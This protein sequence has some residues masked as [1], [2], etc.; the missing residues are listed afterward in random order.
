MDACS[1]QL[2]AAVALLE[3]GQQRGVGG[4]VPELLWLARSLA[5]I[6]HSGSSSSVRAHVAVTGD[7]VSEPIWQCGLLEFSKLSG[8]A[9]LRMILHGSDE[10]T[11]DQDIDER[12]SGC[13][14]GWV[15]CSC[16]R[17]RLF[18]NASGAQNASR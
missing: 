12:C 11:L 15:M 14:C 16:L 8:R 17:H 13:G 5:S 7:E 2:Q 3:L 10:Q 4:Q 9:Q 6:V 1:G 18:T